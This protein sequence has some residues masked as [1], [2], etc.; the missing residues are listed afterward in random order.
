MKTKR[1]IGVL[2]LFLMLWHLAAMSAFAAGESPF[3]DFSNGNI[4]FLSI[5]TAPADAGAAS[6]VIAEE[7]GKNAVKLHVEDAGV[8]YLIVDVGSLL[9]DAVEQLHEAHILI[10][11]E[12][13]DG[14]FQAVS[15][16]IAAYSGLDQIGKTCAWS[17]YLE[18]KNP[19]IARFTLSG[20]LAFSKENAN[21]LIINKKTDNA[22]EVGQAPADLVL[23]EIRL[24]DGEGN[25]LPVYENAQMVLPEGFGEA[26]RSNLI[27]VSDEV[28]IDGAMGVSSGGWGQAVTL[29]AMKNEGMLDTAAIVPGAVITVYYQSNTAPEIILQS[30]TQG[31]PAAAGWAKVTPRAV[32]DS[33]TIAQ[34]VFEDLAMCFGGD[35]FEQFLDQLFVGDTGETLEVSAVTIGTQE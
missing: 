12:N 15:G 10:E 11:T 2:L 4:G 30:W 33:G 22:V 26:D 24:L 8:P 28:G 7:E 3:V 9:G 1:K 32:N 19:N 23:R 13:P 17:V 21:F 18:A 5:Y 25:L 27:A 34:F 35:D 14:E 20:D 6:L 29:L 16:E 31:A